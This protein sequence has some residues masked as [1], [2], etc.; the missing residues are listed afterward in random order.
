MSLVASDPSVKLAAGSVFSNQRDCFAPGDEARKVHLRVGDAGWKAGLVDLPEAVEVGGAKRS[1]VEVHQLSVQ[2]V[3]DCA[4]GLD[5]QP[6][7]DDSAH[8]PRA[9]GR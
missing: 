7:R 3:P 6:A 1:Y 9:R 8:S 4:Q 2:A 5:R